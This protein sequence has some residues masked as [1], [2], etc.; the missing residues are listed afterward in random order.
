[1]R[2]R[3]LPQKSCVV[4][5]EIFGHLLAHKLVMKPVTEIRARRTALE[6][7]LEEL[8]AVFQDRSELTIENSADML[9]TIRMATDRDVSVQRMNISA[10]MLSDVREAL[11]RLEK[12]EYGICEDCEQS[13]PARRLDAIPWALVCV[14]CQEA[15]DRRRTTADDSYPLAA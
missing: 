11:G 4:N 12:G 13:I 7:K 3:I 6:A 15:R 2:Q 14:K 1:M 10:K 8:T 9:D 5:G